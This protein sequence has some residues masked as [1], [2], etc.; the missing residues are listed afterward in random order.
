MH[1][2][3]L[4]RVRDTSQRRIDKSRIIG[5]LPVA[6]AGP[7]AAEH[8]VTMCPGRCAARSAADRCTADPDR[9]KTDLSRELTREIVPVRVNL[10]DQLEFPGAMP[11][12]QAALSC[13]SFV[14]IR[15]LLEVNELD[16]AVLLRE[17]VSERTRSLVTP[18]YKTP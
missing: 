2:Y 4:H 7:G 16:D 1:R 3:A 6:A 14:D 13:T 12:F 10:I 17:P 15:I 5:V 18:T 8:V 9:P 11:A